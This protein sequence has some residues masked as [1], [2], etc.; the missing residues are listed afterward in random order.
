MK[1]KDQCFLPKYSAFFIPPFALIIL[2][3]FLALG[4]VPSRMYADFGFDGDKC[5][6]HLE[7]FSKEPRVIGTKHYNDSVDYIKT[8]LEQYMNDTDMKTNFTFQQDVVQTNNPATKVGFIITSMITTVIDFKSKVSDA[9]ILIINSHIDSH[10]VGPSTYDDGINSAIVLEIA[11]YLS[12]EEYNYNFDIRLIIMGGEEH[13]LQGSYA[14]LNQTPAGY[15]LN[16]ESMG[17]SSPFIMPTKAPK[18]SSTIRA[19]SKVK[20]TI[21][22]SFHNDLI[23]ASFFTS[24]SD[25]RNFETKSV[26]GA[27][28]VFLGNPGHYH[29]KYDAITN[30]TIKDVYKGGNIVAGFI[31]NFEPEDDED[32]VGFG[33]CPMCYSCK[34]KVHL[35]LQIACAVISVFVLA[36]TFEKKVFFNVSCKIL[37]TFIAVGL[38]GIA[39]TFDITN[40]NPGTYANQV[41]LSTL[42]FTLLFGLL[43]GLAFSIPVIGDELSNKDFWCFKLVVFTALGLITAHMDLGILSFY[44]MIE[45]LVSFLFIKWFRVGLMFLYWIFIVPFTYIFVITIRILMGMSTQLAGVIGDILNVML[46]FLFAFYISF[47]ILS[48]CQLPKFELWYFLTASAAAFIIIVTYYNK[49]LAFS[50]FYPIKCSYAHYTEIN[51]S[52]VPVSSTVSVMLDKKDTV[53]PF[54]YKYNETGD[55]IVRKKHLRALVQGTMIEKNATYPNSTIFPIPSIKFEDNNRTMTVS[56]VDVKKNSVEP[57]KNSTTSAIRILCPDEEECIEDLEI[58]R[59]GINRTTF[60]TSP[61][62]FLV[63]GNPNRRAYFFRFIQSISNSSIIFKSK[64]GMEIDA[65]VGYQDWT[66]QLEEFASTFPEYLTQYEKSG[67]FG[68]TVY[69]KKY[70]VE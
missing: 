29:T 60:D 51:S 68:D 27:E 41:T 58:D 62:S 45:T 64:Q 26:T 67:T 14:Y 44:I 36:I 54:F 25:L 32:Q 40:E 66:S 38:L 65:Y 15:L 23:G 20:G 13:G 12:L 69:Y 33:F 10:N 2:F 3:N 70:N 48:F 1:F 22:T 5:M 24:S 47:T 4:Q 56:F 30:R 42:L 46:I 16:L 34:F 49:P 59:F 52:D 37:P 11:H 63:T 28:L 9:P 50:E 31:K 43:F 17:S 7:Y 61:S 55:L 6:E 19:L 18:S 35:G 21:L 8:Q 39:I 57:A 53:V